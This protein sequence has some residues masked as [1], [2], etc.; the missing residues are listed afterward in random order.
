MGSQLQPRQSA[1]NSRALA[2]EG[3]IHAVHEGFRRQADKF[4]GVCVATAKY[5]FQRLK[6]ALILQRFVAAKTA[7]HNSSV[8]ATQSLK[9]G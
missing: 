5:E 2:P 3:R 6:A 9:P 7:T 8:V 1:K 4:Q